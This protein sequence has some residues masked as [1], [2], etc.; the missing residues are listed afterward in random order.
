M[1]PFYVT[2]GSTEVA[3]FPNAASAKAYASKLRG[4]ALR[5]GRHLVSVLERETGKPVP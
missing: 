4:Q 5:P 1:Q 2:I 3:E